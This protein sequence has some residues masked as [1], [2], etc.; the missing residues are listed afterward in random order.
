MKPGIAASSLALAILSSLIISCGPVV[1]TEPQPAGIPA[2]KTFPVSW[3]GMYKLV[4]EE[5]GHDSWMW[6]KTD[7]VLLY[8]D[9]LDSIPLILIEGH[10]SLSEG[11]SAQFTY[12][13]KQLAG[14]VKEEM[15]YYHIT[16]IDVMFLSD[17]LVLKTFGRLGTLNVPEEKAGREYW[18]CALVEP[19]RN[20]DILVWFHSDEDEIGTQANYYEVQELR[21]SGY[22][23]NMLVASPT[24]EEFE[25][26]AEY[27]GFTELAIW[28]TREFQYSDIP[29]VWR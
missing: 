17:S 21:D 8:S 11:D 22:A 4:L 23:S 26:Y 2:E 16:S 19:M 13:G 20:G 9:K 7:T 12:A 24:R 27:E 5:D 29:A 18:Q 10:Q 28:G 6:V 1:Y 15:V 14:V 25:A 3:Q